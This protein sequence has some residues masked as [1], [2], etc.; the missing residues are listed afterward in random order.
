VGRNSTFVFITALIAAIAIQIIGSAIQ[1]SIAGERKTII[2][3]FTSQGCPKS[4]PADVIL[5]QLSKRP[6]IVAL[7]LPVSYWDYMG[8][9]DTLAL[10]ANNNRQKAY[11]RARGVHELYTP[12]MTFNGRI[13]VIGNQQD[14]VDAALERVNA[15]PTSNQVSLSLAK[16]DS[17]VV[18]SAGA[19]KPDSK[20]R[21]ATLWVAFFTST[22]EVNVNKGENNGHR[23]IYTNVVR[24]MFPVGPWKGEADSYHVPIPHGT[25]ID[26]CAAF[27]QNDETKEVLG[28]ALIS[29]SDKQPG[30]SPYQV[31]DQMANSLPE[32]SRK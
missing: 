6:D 27:L 12:Q 31:S 25:D 10:E 29:L 8:W 28:A 22:I 20:P 21:E 23:L 7:T 2:E 32:G 3:L 14:K 17:T 5:R 1:P 30:A 13:H 26:G 16:E 4:P 18:L 11:A 24:K 9:K 19:A 15:E